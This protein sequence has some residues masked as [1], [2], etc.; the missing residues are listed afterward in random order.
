MHSQPNYKKTL[1][2]CYLGYIT[3][4]ITANFTPLLFLTFHNSYGISLDRIALIPTL[5]FLVQ[6]VVD[7][8]SAKFVDKIGYRVCVVAA[9]VFSVVGLV[10]LAALPDLFADPFAGIL[11]SVIIYAMGSGLLEVLVS[12]IVEA[13][14]FD[15][16]E[17]AM[18]LLHS[19]YCWGAVLVILGSTL[20][21][22]IFG[23][24]KWRLLACLWAIVPL[25][26]IY[27]Y[28]TCPIAPLVA[29]GKGMSIGELLRTK[30]FWLL[31]LLMVCS[32]ASELSMAQWASAFTESALKVSKTVGDLAGPCLFAALQGVSRVFYGKYSDRFDLTK[33]MLGSGALC[34]TCYLLSSLTDAPILGLIGCALC[35]LSVGIMW[36]G[37]FSIAAQKCRAG[38]TALFALLALAGDLGGS[39]GPSVVG[40]FSSIAGDNLKM[41]ILAAVIFPILLI[42]GIIILR[43]KFA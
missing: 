11:L 17:G 42:A 3:Q 30:L 6:L 20:F 13:C 25:I 10:G 33:F 38:G 39:I 27:N 35:G 22:G 24:E 21:F 37:T 41:G 7:F 28:A 16:K 34:V 15:N 31:A 23:I 19:F 40:V 32:G 36:P 9:E 18:S 8:A 5:F 14:P 12:P 1:T 4:A 2:A 43:K 26:N 29:E